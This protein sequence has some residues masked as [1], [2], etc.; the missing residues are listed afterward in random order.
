L[1]IWVFAFLDKFESGIIGKWVI[2]MAMGSCIFESEEQFTSHIRLPLPLLVNLSTTWR[3][4]VLRA[5]LV[6]PEA[7]RPSS[8]PGE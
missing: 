4:G 5:W 3:C 8:S 2:S 1:L 7:V 6:C